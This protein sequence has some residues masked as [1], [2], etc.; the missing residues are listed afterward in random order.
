MK[1]SGLSCTKKEEGIILHQEEEVQ[2]FDR[3]RGAP[4]HFSSC[5]SEA[6]ADLI[7]FTFP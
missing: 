7:V 2:N 6:E 4:N 1:L 5:F 3:V